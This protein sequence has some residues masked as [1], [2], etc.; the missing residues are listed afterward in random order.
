MQI[1]QRNVVKEM[2]NLETW[3]LGPGFDVDGDDDDDEDK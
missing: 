3:V 1:I 2:L